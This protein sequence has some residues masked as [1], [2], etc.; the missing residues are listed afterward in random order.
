VDCAT[1]SNHYYFHFAQEFVT[2][3]LAYMFDSLVRVSRRGENNNLV[4]VNYIID[5]KLH[6]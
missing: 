5:S 4:N 6:A 2:L 1:G 3:V